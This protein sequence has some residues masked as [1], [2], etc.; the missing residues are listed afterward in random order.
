MKSARN[1]SGTLMSQPTQSSGE[2][3]RSDSIAGSL[4]NVTSPAPGPARQPAKQAAKSG[5]P[6]RVASR[7]RT[8]GIMNSP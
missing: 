1:W 5:R 4:A 6:G 7:Q 2:H 8:R 3:G